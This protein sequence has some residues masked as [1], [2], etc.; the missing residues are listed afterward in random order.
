MLA[1]GS[2]ED[3]SQVNTETFTKKRNILSSFYQYRYAV[4]LCGLRAGGLVQVTSDIPV[5][6][7]HELGSCAGLLRLTRAR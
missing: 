3:R 5:G 1:I 2:F 6:G 4:G 7:I